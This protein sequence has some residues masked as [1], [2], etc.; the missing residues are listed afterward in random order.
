LQ[1]IS[2]A[3]KEGNKAYSA[4]GSQIY[5]DIEKGNKLYADIL[6]ALY[7]IINANSLMI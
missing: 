4:F 2:K 1:H 3:Y 6:D 5:N 7:E